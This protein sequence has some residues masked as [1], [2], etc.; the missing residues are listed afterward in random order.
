MFGLWATI[1]GFSILFF[2]M[3][4]FFLLTIKG[5]VDSDDAYRVDPQP[6]KDPDNC[7]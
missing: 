6:E 2:A 7:A 5:A 4:Y 3:V 1:T